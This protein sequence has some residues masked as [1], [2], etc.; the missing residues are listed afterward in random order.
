[1][2]G[3]YESEEIIKPKSNSRK[4]KIDKLKT[5]LDA[6]IDEIEKTIAR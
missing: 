5:S 6:S 1:M 4:A 2:L 3:D